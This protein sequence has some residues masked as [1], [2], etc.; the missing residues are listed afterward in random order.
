MNKKP[1]KVNWK[2]QDMPSPRPL[3]RGLIGI[4]MTLLFIFF[5][6]KTYLE[7][8]PIGIGIIFG[9]GGLMLIFYEIKIIKMA[10]KLK[11]KKRGAIKECKQFNLEQA[12]PI[13]TWQGYYL[14]G[15]L[16][17]I[18]P[19]LIV[20]SGLIFFISQ[21]N[22]FQWF[23]LII[24]ILIGVTVIRVI[25]PR[26]LLLIKIAKGLKNGDKKFIRI[27]RKNPIFQQGSG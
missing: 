14:T 21:P 17:I 11:K 9:L 4:I 10:Y 6:F 1:V 5:I 7:K 20:V 27:A 3:A 22:N 18:L 16:G 15:I 26:G 19:I 13:R 12:S 2:Y 25:P 8:V 24:W 23:Y